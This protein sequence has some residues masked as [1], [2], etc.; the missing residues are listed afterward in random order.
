[1]EKPHKD[2]L[3]ERWFEKS[4]DAIKTAELNLEANL[5]TSALN[6]IYYGIFYVVMGLA[7]KHDFKT[8]KHAKLMGWFNKKFIY[9]N[10]T[11]SPEIFEVYKLSFAHRQN[12]DYDAMYTPDLETATRL[13]ADAKKFIE[14]VK[15]VI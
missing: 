3:I 1:M 13:L 7:E 10:K 15:K 11:F 12:S 2:I 6:R 4:D 5:L 9:E 14:E 8:S